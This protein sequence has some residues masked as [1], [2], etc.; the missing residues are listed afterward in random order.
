MTED[1][2]NID[3][4]D[5]EAL[6][7]DTLELED[8]QVGVNPSSLRSKSLSQASFKRAVDS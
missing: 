1:I 8:D 6:A 5:I 2:D 4:L 7:A 3:K